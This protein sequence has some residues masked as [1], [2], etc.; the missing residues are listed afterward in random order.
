MFTRKRIII[1]AV[2]IFGI[3]ALALAWWLLSP[4]FITTTVNEDFPLA[5]NAVLPAE[6]VM[7][8]GE[9]VMV[10]TMADAETMMRDAAGEFEK[11]DERV[12]SEM[13]MPDNSS[14]MDASV[15]KV[16][17]GNFRDADS[18]HKGSGTATIYR[19]AEGMHVLRL[20]DFR[21]TN[22]PELHVLLVPNAN[23]QGR[24]DVQGYLGLG[25]LKGNEG[26]QNYFLPDGED[27]EGYGSVVIYCRP[28]HVV[29]SVATLE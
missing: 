12:P 3:P 26:N 14:M 5:A 28:F 17:T 19:S 21:V 9:T 27:G 18:F 24:D 8:G 16:K 1:G 15:V 11:Y 23:P 22:G 10:E 4:L 29:F 25:K 7:D 20:E 6:V 13:A 2:V